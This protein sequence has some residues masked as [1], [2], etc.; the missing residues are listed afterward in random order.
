MEFVLNGELILW[1]L[2]FISLT[3]HHHYPRAG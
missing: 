2:G 1:V 3:G